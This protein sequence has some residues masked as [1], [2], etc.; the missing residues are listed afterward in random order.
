MP[1]DF[2]ITSTIDG[3][4][5]CIHI[6]ISYI[7]YT[8]TYLGRYSY[9]WGPDDDYDDGS[10]EYKAHVLSVCCMSYSTYKYVLYIHPHIYV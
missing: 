6:S 9:M 8:Y 7:T 10:Y 5:E 1:R 3:R 4:F 2:G